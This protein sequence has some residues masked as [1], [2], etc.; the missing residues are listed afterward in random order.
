[1]Y[2]IRRRSAADHLVL[3]SDSTGFAC[4]PPTIRAECMKYLSS[5]CD[6]RRTFVPAPQKGALSSFPQT[7]RRNQTLRPSIRI[8][9]RV[10]TEIAA[11]SSSG[12]AN[13]GGLFGERGRDEV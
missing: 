2:A 4:R 12:T 13:W 5:R 7:E 10:A 9:F 1:M 3:A 6:R 8:A 11:R